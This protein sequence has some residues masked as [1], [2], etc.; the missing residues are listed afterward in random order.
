MTQTPA[1]QTRW[2]RFYENVWLAGLPRD[3]RTLA[4]TAA[5]GFV[6]TALFVCLALQGDTYGL[7]DRANLKK[8]QGTLSHVAKNK[9]DVVFR[10]EPWKATFEYPAKARALARVAAALREGAAASVL[11]NG[12]TFVND[13]AQRMTIFALTVDGEIVRSFDEVERAWRAD[14]RVFHWLTAVFG[15]ATLALAATAFT[16]YRRGVR[17]G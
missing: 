6:L 10:L 16:E 8:L 1:T 13:G 14:N 12:A 15:S 3:W 4:A 11:V 17:I 2:S 7:P 9:Y 5:V